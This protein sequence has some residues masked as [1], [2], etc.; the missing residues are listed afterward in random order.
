MQQQQ[1]QPYNLNSTITTKRQQAPG[2]A[3]R[4]VR[5]LYDFEAVEDNE[6]SFSVGEIITVSDDRCA[7]F[8]PSF[9]STTYVG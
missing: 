9:Y 6:L 8:A 1:Q 7:F 4:Q 2:A 3:R 5:A